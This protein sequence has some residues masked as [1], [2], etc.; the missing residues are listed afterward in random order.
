MPP[1][2]NQDHKRTLP[3]SILGSTVMNL[4]S[5]LIKKSLVIQDLQSRTEPTYNGLGFKALQNQ[6]DSR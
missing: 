6:E 3:C 5:T 4:D 2:F 1:S